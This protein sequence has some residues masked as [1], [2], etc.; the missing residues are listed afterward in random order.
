M[1]DLSPASEALSLV[2]RND[3]NATGDRQVTGHMYCPA[4]RVVANWHNGEHGGA[5]GTCQEQPCRAV[6][7]VCD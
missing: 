5:Y 2:D 3:V 1:G 4:E 7:A 6:R